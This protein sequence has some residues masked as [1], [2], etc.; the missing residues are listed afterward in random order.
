M[1][2]PPRQEGRKESTKREGMNNKDILTWACGLL[3]LGFGLVAQAENAIIVKTGKFKL[4]HDTQTLDDAPRSI[5]DDARNIT[6]LGWED[7]AGD[8]LAQG[9]EFVRYTN[10]WRSPASVEGD[11]TSRLLM[12]TIKKYQDRG[13][14]YPYFGAGIGLAHANVGGGGIK[15]D[16]AIGLAL[17]IIGGVELRFEGFGLYTELKGLYAESGNFGG[18]DVNVSGIGLFVG[19]SILL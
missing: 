4:T 6:G 19:F 16:P 8:G 9:V 2:K 18:D 11:I 10:R 1:K 3:L 7:R 5:D 12:F 17:Q 14:Y 13:L 15:L